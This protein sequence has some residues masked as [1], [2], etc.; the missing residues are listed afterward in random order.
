M[1]DKLAAPNNL[2]S[3][4]I[5]PVLVPHPYEMRETFAHARQIMAQPGT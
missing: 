1:P 5:G 3:A 2:V 4:K